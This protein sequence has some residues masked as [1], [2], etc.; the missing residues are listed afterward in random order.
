MIRNRN[1]LA[2]EELSSFFEVRRLAG[3][4]P[5]MFGDSSFRTEPLWSHF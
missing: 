4:D 3:E 2:M 5:G 1:I